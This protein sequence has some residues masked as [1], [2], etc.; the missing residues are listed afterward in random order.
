MQKDIVNI[1]KVRLKKRTSDTHLDTS[2]SKIKKIKKKNR[3]EGDEHLHNCLFFPIL[4][5]RNNKTL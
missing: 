2:Y 1:F 4:E 5:E 3:G